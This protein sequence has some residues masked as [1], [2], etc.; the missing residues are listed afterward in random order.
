VQGAALNPGDVVS[1]YRIEST[2][3]GGGMGVVYL[4]DDVT[5]GRKVALK[6]LSSEVASDPQAL[7]RFR[8]EARAASALNHPNICTIYEIGEHEGRPFIAME[9]LDGRTLRQRLGEG[10]LSIDEFLVLATEVADA[11]DVAHRAGVVHRDIKPAN[12]FLV[13]RGSTS[14]PIEGHHSERKPSAAGE[15]VSAKLLDFG[16]AKLDT[17]SLARSALPTLPNEADLTSPGTTLGTIGYMSPEQARGERLDPRTDLFSFG[18]VLYELATRTPPFSGATPAVVFHEILSKEPAPPSRLNPNVPPDLDRLILKALEKDRDVRCQSAA[19]MLSDLKRLRRDRDSARLSSSAIVSE[20]AAASSTRIGVVPPVS[21]RPSASSDAQI[22][23]AIARRHRG[24]LALGAIGIAIAAASIAY[25]LFRSSLRPLSSSD[26]I[27]SL[28]NLEVV[29]LTTSGNAARPAISPDGKYVAYVQ[30]D[31][32]NFSL[33]IRQTATASNVQIMPPRPGVGLMGVTVTP[34]GSYVDFV[35]NSLE[36][37]RARFSLWRVPFL[38]G[39][40]RRLVDDVFSPVGWSPDGRQMAFLRWDLRDAS[41]T[42]LVIADADG[43]NE[44]VLVTQRS[45]APRFLML[46][47]PGDRDLRPAWS[48]D[49]RTIAAFGFEE[50]EGRLTGSMVF[51]TAADGTVRSVP[52][53]TTGTGVDW[54]DNSSLVLSRPAESGALNQVWRLSYPDGR[55]SRLTNDLSSYVGANLSGDRTTLATGR[56]EARVAIWVGDGSG[57]EGAEVVTNAA[58]G[59]LPLKSIAWAG[60]K[61]VYTSRSGGNLALSLRS[62]GGETTEAVVTH[63]DSPSATSDGRTIVYVAKQPGAA[64][65]LWKADADGRRATQL[66]PY[67]VSWPQ[68]TRDD[69]SVVFMSSVKTGTPTPWIMPLDGGEPTKVADLN[70]RFLDLS[71]DGRIVAFLTLDRQNQPRTVL[72]ELPVCVSPRQLEIPPGPIRWTPDGLAIA[73]VALLTIARGG[74]NIRVFP[75][76]GSP[77]RQLTHFADDREIQDFAWSR[78]GK[79]LAVVRTAVSRDIVLF[80]GLRA[81]N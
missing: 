3:G 14:S 58:L 1:H 52:L 5:L 30:Q 7:E 70:V 9:W 38:G 27:A 79:R 68:V 4:A 42:D 76:D 74:S 35:N 57:A 22:V 31:S 12:I 48:P 32:A 78:D 24:A 20:T 25:I 45:P 59:D 26:S 13:S 8:R 56:T 41:R 80:K 37:G 19:E 6:F 33:W 55:S 46:G 77:S 51:V 34:D 28:Q 21:D 53:E 73:S 47:F 2:L 15:R 62:P 44:H 39:T 65:S 81:G 16:L 40:P 11:L 61:L 54:V 64:E 43:T 17:A 72:C 36:E 50:S 18:V 67:T 60:D 66:V 69:R 49:G 75:L 10:W 29:Q 23:A 71:P 63:A